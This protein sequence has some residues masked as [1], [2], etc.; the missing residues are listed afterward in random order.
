[1][2]VWQ[3]LLQQEK[4][5]ASAIFIDRFPITLKFGCTIHTKDHLVDSLGCK[6]VRSHDDVYQNL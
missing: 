4:I 2:S 1:M 5:D 6:D 3:M